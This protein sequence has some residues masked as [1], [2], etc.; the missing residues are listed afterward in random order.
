MVG[1]YDDA[2]AALGRYVAVFSSLTAL[3]RNLFATR[4]TGQGE[5]GIERELLDYA[6]AALTAEPI[7]NAFFA[8]GRTLAEFDKA[9]Q[10]IEA[11]LRKAVLSECTRRNDIVHGDWLFDEF[12]EG[13]G[14]E[15]VP[16]AV[17]LGGGLRVNYLR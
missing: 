6:L 16:L 7:A 1:P 12:G 15:D 4:I 9:E 17:E 10:S 11:A 3:M 8:T 13:G 14:V 5:Q 2:F